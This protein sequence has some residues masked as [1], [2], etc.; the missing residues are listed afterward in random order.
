[1]TKPYIE[2]ITN[3]LSFMAG[4]T[5]AVRI[6]NLKLSNIDVQQEYVSKKR[7]KFGYYL[8]IPLF[9]FSKGSTLVLHNNDM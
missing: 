7:S 6:R 9:C 4:D 5:I 3:I 8:R 1:M 2:I